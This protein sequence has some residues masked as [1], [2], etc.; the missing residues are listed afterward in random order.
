[1]VET[2]YKPSVHNGQSVPD[3]MPGS[4]DL[5]AAA[6][7][8]DRDAFGQLYAR[9]APGVARYVSHRVPDPYLAQDFTSE[10][11]ARALRRIDSVS[12]QG[13]DVG[14]W[15]ITIAR[16]LLADHWKSHRTQRETPV[17]TVADGLPNQEFSPEQAVIA[18]ETAA[19]VRAA[20]ARLTPAQREVIRLRY[21][22]ELPV[23]QVAAVT[24]RTDG[25]VKALAHRGVAALRAEL[26]TPPRKPAAAGRTAVDP[27]IRARRAVTEMTTRVA[28]EQRRAAEQAEAR[29]TARWQAVDATVTSE[30]GHDRDAVVEGVACCG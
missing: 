7:A 9:Y 4:W 29:R 3:V 2:I 26:A 6:Q 25:A 1:M 12:D 28:T 10:T 24:G 8:G 14:A 18:A 11:F 27:L 15:L 17:A 23:A 5:V 22:D 20:V 21:F 30:Q 13:R 16:N 19:D